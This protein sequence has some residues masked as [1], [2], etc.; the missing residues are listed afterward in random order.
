MSLLNK[1]GPTTPQ[2]QALPDTS[3]KAAYGGY[4][5]NAAGCV[6]CHSKVNKGAIVAGTE[7]G[8]G[9]EFRQPAG[10]L[11]APNITMHPTAGIGKWTKEVFIQRFNVYRNPEN[12]PKLKSGELNTPMPWSMY[13]GMKASDLEAIYLYLKSLPPKENV[14]NVREYVKTKK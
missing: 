4:L 7:F 9:M 14:V 5:I 6:D 1:L 12:L 11:R 10:I 8:G 2:H 3:N 13:A